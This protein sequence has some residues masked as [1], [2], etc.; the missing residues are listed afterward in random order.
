MAYHR[1][2]AE[3]K[4]LLTPLHIER[5]IQWA[6][7][8][9]RWAFDMWRR[10]LWTD[11]CTIRLGRFG[12]VYVTRRAEEKYD[13][14]CVVPMIRHQPGLMIAGAISGVG[15]GPLVIFEPNESV[16]AQVYC[17][18]VLPGLYNEIKRM[19]R[20][21]IGPLRGILMEDNASPHTAK[22]TQQQQAQWFLF[23]KMVW[24]A[25]SPD[26]N[27]IEN[28][29]RLLKYRIQKH[30]PKNLIELRRVIEEEWEALEPSD[31]LKYI[32][33]M[34]ER[35]QAVIDNNGGHTQW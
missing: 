22:Y 8:H 1:R 11:E 31:Y 13:A 4:P 25:N 7:R 12:K 26:L 10:V 2:V 17:D 34:P 20:E 5:R 15:K 32:E 19:E 24:P 14:S 30:K 18:K 35:C 3:E 9:L 28:V 23:N 6:I 16:T 33:S 27:P 29:W 21:H